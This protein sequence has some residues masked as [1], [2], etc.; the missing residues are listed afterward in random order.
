MRDNVEDMV[1]D[2]RG[3]GVITIFIDGFNTH[4]PKTNACFKTH[5]KDNRTSDSARVTSLAL[6][7]CKDDRLSIT[8]LC[9]LINEALVKLGDDVLCFGAADACARNGIQGLGKVFTTGYNYNC[10]ECNC[11]SNQYWRRGAYV[12][13]ESGQVLTDAVVADMDS[14]AIRDV[15]LFMDDKRLVVISFV[16]VISTHSKIVP[17]VI[18]PHI[19]SGD[20]FDTGTSNG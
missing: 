12:K 8:E 14:S 9:G 1:K 20:S 10:T 19:V 4:G 2:M 15:L 3:R 18:V 16:M 7:D 6:C 17:I 5:S 13:D 11:P